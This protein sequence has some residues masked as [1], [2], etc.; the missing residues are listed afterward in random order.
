[1]AKLLAKPY[2]APILRTGSFEDYSKATETVYQELLKKSNSL[3]DDEVEGALLSFPVADG[4]ALYLVTKAS[5]LTLQHVPLWDAY[6]I[7]AA[8]LSG[9]RLAHVQAQVKQARAWAN[10]MDKAAQPA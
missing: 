1:M 3:D 4:S 9:L 8:H 5:P 2:P 7:P 10:L 6:Q